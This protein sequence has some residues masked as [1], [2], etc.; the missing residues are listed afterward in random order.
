[1]KKIK[2]VKE[3]LVTVP[4]KRNSMK[5]L[6]HTREMQFVS[7]YNLMFLHEIEANLC[8]IGNYGYSKKYES[9]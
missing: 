1:M 8:H 4:E 5:N 2:Y 6:C 3:I 9:L 7:D